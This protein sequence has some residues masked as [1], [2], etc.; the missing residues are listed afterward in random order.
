MLRA[1]T[2]PQ[3]VQPRIRRRVMRWSASKMQHVR[4]VQTPLPVDHGITF[5][6]S[7]CG[8][9]II[10]SSTHCEDSCLIR[11]VNFKVRSKSSR[12]CQ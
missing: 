2:R 7:S 10:L 9:D 12:P 3:V 1:W 4:M 6:P 8:F 11:Q 5:H